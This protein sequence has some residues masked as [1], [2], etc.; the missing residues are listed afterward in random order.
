MEV[1]ATAKAAD[2]AAWRAW[3][4]LHHATDP[5]IGSRPSSSAACGAS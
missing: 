5:E 3:L 1:G 2:R 4:E